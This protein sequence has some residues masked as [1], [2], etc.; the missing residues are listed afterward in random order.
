MLIAVNGADG[1]A[2]LRQMYTV[3]AYKIYAKQGDLK[4]DSVHVPNLHTVLFLIDLT[5]I[6]S[7]S[8]VDTASVVF[9]GSH[10]HHTLVDDDV[11][12]RTYLSYTER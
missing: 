3:F 1:L 6:L 12:R 11:R 4:S 5:A 10:L 7:R 8:K 2:I 9:H